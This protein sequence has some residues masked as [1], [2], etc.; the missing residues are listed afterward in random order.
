M[1]ALLSQSLQVT[2]N[3]ESLRKAADEMAALLKQVK[4]YGILSKKQAYHRL[5]L[6]NDLTT[7]HLL[8]RAAL[9]AGPEHGLPCPGRRRPPAG[10]PVTGSSSRAP[11]KAPLLQ[12]QLL[13]GESTP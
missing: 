8:A 2:R 1:Q 13:Q 11:I 4:E 6:I 3:E 7:A 9:G 12:R 10:A 5:R